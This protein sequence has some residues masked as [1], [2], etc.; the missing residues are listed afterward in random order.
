[1]TTT[2]IALG[3]EFNIGG[4]NVPA[5]AVAAAITGKRVRLR[6]YRV[7]SFVVVQNTDAGT[8]DDLAVD[9]QEHNAATGGTSQDLDIITDY[10]MQTETALD[11]DETWARTTQT[12][13]SEITAIAGMAEVELVLVV[14]VYRDQLSDGFDWVSL[15]IPDLGTTDVL[16]TAIIPILTGL[17]VQRDPANLA[18][19]Q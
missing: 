8:A 14:E 4:V 19:T 6:D 17:D 13:A 9:L 1:M 18:A 2:A 5:D 16:W 15:N 10:F 12:A 3:R 11:G 7:C